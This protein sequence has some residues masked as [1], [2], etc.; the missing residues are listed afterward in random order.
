[1]CRCLTVKSACGAVL[2]MWT[3]QTT[4][5]TTQRRW[6]DPL[7][8]LTG[9]STRTCWALFLFLQQCKRGSGLREFPVLLIQP[10]APEKPWTSRLLKKKNTQLVKYWRRHGQSSSKLYFEH[11]VY[12]LAEFQPHLL[13]HWLISSDSMKPEHRATTVFLHS[14][15][16]YRLFFCRFVFLCLTFRLFD[17]F[18]CWLKL[19]V[20]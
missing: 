14:F 2:Q 3:K 5:S 12:H 17:S 6:I 4:T 19:V 13:S 8:S 9:N 15:A 7:V 18:I 20:K 10:N 11:Q 1:M 16:F